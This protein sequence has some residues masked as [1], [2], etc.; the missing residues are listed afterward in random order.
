V[1][2]QWAKVFLPYT[3]VEPPRPS[4]VLPQKLARVGV[5]SSENGSSPTNP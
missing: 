1:S 2:G 3:V 4:Q 5:F